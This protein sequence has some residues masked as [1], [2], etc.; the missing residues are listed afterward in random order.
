MTGVR[1]GVAKQISSEES[2]AVFIH[3]YGHAL[4]LAVADTIKQIE[5]MF[6]MWFLRLPSL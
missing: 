4:N 2:R 3:C 1:N 5:M 6:L